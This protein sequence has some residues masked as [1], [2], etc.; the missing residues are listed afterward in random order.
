MIVVFTIFNGITIYFVYYNWYLIKKMFLAL[1][2]ILKNL[3]KVE[4][5]FIEC[6]SAE[7]INGRNKTN[8]C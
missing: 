1:N 6:S 4:C 7:Y 8:K 3:V 2:L 5:S